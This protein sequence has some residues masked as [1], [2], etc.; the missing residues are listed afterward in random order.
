MVTSIC[1]DVETVE[2][3]EGGRAGQRKG[4]KEL[5]QSIEIPDGYYIFWGVG[6]GRWGGGGGLRE[7]QSGQEERSHILTKTPSEF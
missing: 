2:G 1:G 7:E 3:A 4:S 6:G 5:G